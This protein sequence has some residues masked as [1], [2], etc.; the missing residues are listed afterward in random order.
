MIPKWGKVPNYNIIY[1]MVIKYPK[2]R[3]TIPNGHKI[4]QHFPIKDPPKF[5]KI[6]I[7]G[8]EINHLATLERS[9]NKNRQLPRRVRGNLQTLQ[10]T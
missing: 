4:C 5:T 6:G 2:Y 9:T 10:L 7:F 3:V 1:Q 8:L